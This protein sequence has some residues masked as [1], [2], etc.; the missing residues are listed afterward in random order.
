MHMLFVSRYRDANPVPT[1]Q[2][3][4]D[5]ATAPPVPAD[6]AIATGNSELL[7]RKQ[8]TVCHYIQY[9]TG[10]LKTRS[11]L[12]PVPRCEPSIYQPIS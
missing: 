1:N 8:A 3:A 6:P 5:R 10:P 12:E 9:P 7:C 11:E 4:D 2:L